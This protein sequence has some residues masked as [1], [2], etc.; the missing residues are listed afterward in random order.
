[1]GLTGRPDVMS[2]LTADHDNIRRAVDTAVAAGDASIALRIGAAMV[3][4]WTSHGDWTEGRQRL[5]AALAMPSPDLRLRGR[6][7]VAIGNLELM[8]VD[9]ASAEC[10]LHRGGVP[11]R[12]L[13][14]TT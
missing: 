2:D 8:R 7:L 14:E 12:R 13:P 5:A 1:M 10:P 11:P 3:P 6:A 9:L 4:Y